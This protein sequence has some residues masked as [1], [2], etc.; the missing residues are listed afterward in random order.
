MLIA[1]GPQSLPEV[2][3]RTVRPSCQGAV[4]RPGSLAALPWPPHPPVCSCSFVG[5]TPPGQAR[6]SLQR[7]LGKPTLLPPAATLENLAEARP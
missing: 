2:T 7:C 6:R 3:E 1:R 4:G 5:L